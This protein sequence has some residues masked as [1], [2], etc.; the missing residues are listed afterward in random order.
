MSQAGGALIATVAIVV[1]THHPALWAAGARTAA[2]TAGVDTSDGKALSRSAGVA[3]TSAVDIT[4]GLEQ[5]KRQ[6][7]DR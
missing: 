4:V 3:Q 6:M 7:A 2:G 5:P 1:S